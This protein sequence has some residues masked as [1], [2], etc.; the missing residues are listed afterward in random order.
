MEEVFNILPGTVNA[1]QGAAM[2]HSPDQAF[3]FH[4]QVRFRDRPNWPDLKLDADFGDQVPP[5]SHNLPHSSTPDHTGAIP[6]NSLN[7]TFNISG[8]LPLSGNSQDAATIAAE[9]SAAAA[10]KHRRSSGTWGAQDYQI[11]GQIFK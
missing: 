7:C 6:V 8:I 3:S 2:Y 4:K 10:A 5:S 9:V 1:T 11:Q